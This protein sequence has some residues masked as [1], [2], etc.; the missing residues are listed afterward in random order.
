MN[1]KT[2]KSSLKKTVTRRTITIVSLSIFMLVLSSC[3]WWHRPNI[4]GPKP[5]PP[6]PLLP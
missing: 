3:H 5:R 4:P 1:K 6:L 2:I